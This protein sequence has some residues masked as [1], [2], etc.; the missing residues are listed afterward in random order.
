MRDALY[1]DAAGACPRRGPV[2][3]EDRAQSC[4][5]VTA[6]RPRLRARR[7]RAV[8]KDSES[9]VRPASELGQLCN[10]T[11]RR[12]LKEDQARREGAC[13]E[14]DVTPSSA[15][16]ALVP[17][18]FFK[19]TQFCRPFERRPVPLASPAAPPAFPAPADHLG[20]CERAECGQEAGCRPETLRAGRLPQGRRG[21]VDADV[22]QAR[23]S[24]SGSA[25]EASPPP[26]IPSTGKCLSFVDFRNSSCF[27][28][29]QRSTILKPQKCIAMILLV[30]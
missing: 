26:S 11:R 6:L 27:L 12:T 3:F 25:T 9:G 2:C 14:Q 13:L 1:Q 29:P 19:C 22:T 5:A 30:S 20:A 8:S 23:L 16:Y 17:F 18:S 7:A 15:Q 24:P 4:F 10:W 28:K 21:K